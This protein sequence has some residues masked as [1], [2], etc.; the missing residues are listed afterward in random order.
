MTPAPAGRPSALGTFIV[1]AAFAAAPRPSAADAVDDFVR[2]HMERHH[3]PGLSVAICRDGQLVKAQGYG[4]ANV[5]LD[6]EAKPETIFQSGSV[7]KQFTAM[8]VMLL[9]EEGKLGL[10][11]PLR[12]TLSGRPVPG[13]PSRYGTS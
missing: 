7:G 4:L 3:I 5:E 11:D 9:V 10:D 13:R 8:A 1:L 2:A 12:N 6:V